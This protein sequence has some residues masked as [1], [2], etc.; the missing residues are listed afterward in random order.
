MLSSLAV[1]QLR[2][3]RFLPDTLQPLS[4]TV[5]L[6]RRLHKQ[7]ANRV[8]SQKRPLALVSRDDTI[9]TSTLSIRNLELEE[10]ERNSGDIAACRA[11][12]RQ[13]VNGL[14]QHAAREPRTPRYPELVILA[15]EAVPRLWRLQR[16]PP[17]IA[18]PVVHE[19]RKRVRRLVH[20]DIDERQERGEASGVRVVRVRALEVLDEVL[21]EADTAGTPLDLSRHELAVWRGGQQRGS[22]VWVRYPGCASARAA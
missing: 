12:K 3:L 19:C 1:N 15:V 17:Q 21:A 18:M 6:P 10:Y 5:P 2:P 22:G 8:G 7:H 20:E 13:C 14:E 9:P 4:R 16:I 11:A